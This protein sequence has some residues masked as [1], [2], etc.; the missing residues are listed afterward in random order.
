MKGHQTIAYQATL[1]TPRWRQL[2]WRRLMVAGFRCERC[3]ARFTGKSPKAAFRY[4]DLHH[5]T[6][7]RFG[8]EALDD[9]RILCRPCHD[10]IER[11]KRRAA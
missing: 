4:F 10:E 3:S 9:V 7:R 1:A 11:E 5:V 6:Y 2:K 8:H